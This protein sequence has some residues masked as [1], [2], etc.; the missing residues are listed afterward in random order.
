VI[1][2]TFDDNVIPHQFAVVRV[3]DRQDDTTHSVECV[4]VL[5]KGDLEDRRTALA[6]E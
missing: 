2:S 5:V 3:A 4:Q 1:C 6:V